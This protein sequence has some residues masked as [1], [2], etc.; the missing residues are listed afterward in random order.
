MSDAFPIMDSVDSIR[1]SAELARKVIELMEQNKVPST[2]D[3]FAVW[4]AYVDGGNPDLVKAINDAQTGADGFTESLNSEFHQRF[5]E[6]ASQAELMEI[7]RRIEGAV[8]KVL[9]YM[10]SAANRANQYG[11]SLEAF[12]G[13]LSKQQ[14]PVEMSSLVNDILQATRTMISTNTQLSQRLTSTVKE[15]TQL[16]Q[17]VEVLKRE[18]SIDHLTKLYNRKWLDQV[19][20]EAVADA[21]QTRKPLALIIVD[22]DFFKQFNDT[23]GHLLGDQVLK[24]VAQTIIDGTD[25][26]DTAARYGGEEFAIVL[27]NTKMAAALKK[28]ETIR[29]RLAD[30]KVT[31]RNTGKVLGQVTLSAGVAC[32]RHGEAMSDLIARADAALY[33]A[34]HNGRNRVETENE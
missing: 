29:K 23:Y 33:S 25:P 24:L 2:P 3:N 7:G 11:S 18:V 28:A 12:S 19:L 15:A 32:Y 22:I 26:E 20:E 13:E 8:A 17:D 27:P 10:G 6:G 1:T 5:L 30:R 21:E 16:K 4:H 9:E 34:K 31:N 14:S